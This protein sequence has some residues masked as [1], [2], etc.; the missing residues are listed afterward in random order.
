MADRGQEEAFISSLTASG[1][2]YRDRILGSCFSEEGE[3]L[4]FTGWAMSTNLTTKMSIQEG[5]LKGG[6]VGRGSVG[7]T[8]AAL[9][10]E[11]SNPVNSM[12]RQGM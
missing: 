12:V 10:R 4:P 11:A 3:C 7:P 9:L 1:R 2:E 8:L 6:R 5:T